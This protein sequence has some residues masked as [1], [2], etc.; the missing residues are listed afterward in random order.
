M[1]MTYLQEIIFRN[2]VHRHTPPVFTQGFIN[3]H[4]DGGG[5]DSSLA[6]VLCLQAPKVQAAA[7]SQ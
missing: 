2:V 7:E 6:P 1:I 5:G 4:E 3:T